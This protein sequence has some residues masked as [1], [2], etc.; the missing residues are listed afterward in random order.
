MNS[1]LSA[2][3]AALSAV[4]LTFAFAPAQA[5]PMS[6]DKNIA[7]NISSTAVSVTQVKKRGRAYHKH[8]EYRKR[9]YYRNRGY[10]RDR[11]YY[12]N[13]GYYGYGGYYPR[14][15]RGTYFSFGIGPSYPSNF[16]LGYYD[17]PYYSD[18]YDYGFP[19]TYEPDYEYRPAYRY[20][21]RG[22]SKAADRIFKQQSEDGP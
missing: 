20:K 4:L 8:R 6:L 12:R 15:Y 11:G 17:Y 16:G 14:R 13:R 1:V 10:Y 18:R 21:Y 5:G 2:V 3:P 19:Y 7:D 22:D 9:G